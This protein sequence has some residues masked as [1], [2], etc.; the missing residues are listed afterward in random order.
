MHLIYGPLKVYVGKKY[1][2]K[3]AAKKCTD[4]AACAVEENCKAVKGTPIVNRKV[5]KERNF[6]LTKLVTS[7]HTESS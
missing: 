3:H 4:D 7:V 1:H 5:G 2:L 6:I